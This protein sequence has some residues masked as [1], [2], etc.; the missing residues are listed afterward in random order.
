MDVRVEGQAVTVEE[1]SD[2]ASVLK[3]ALSGKRFK[4]V[5]AASV[6]GT[7]HDLSSVVPAGTGEIT[8][9]YADSPEGLEMIR[10]STAHVMALAVQR[11]FPGVLVTIGPAIENGFYYDFDVETPFTQADLEKIEAEMHKIAR[12]RIPFTRSELARAEAVTRFG[13]MGEKYK[14]EIIRDIEADHV[15]LYQLDTFCDLCRGPHVPHTG[16]CDH[17]R[18]LSCAGAYWRGDE[19]NRMLSRIYGTAFADEKSLKEHL[20]RLEEAKRRDHRKLGRELGFFTF[21]EHVAPGMVFWLPNGMLMRTILEDFWK[22]E[23]LKRGYQIVQGPQLLRQETW[24][25]S[26][27]YEHYRQN[28]YFT[29]IDEEK[30]GIK[31]MNCIGH[32]LMYGNA[33]HSYRDMPVRLFELGCVHRHEKSGVL[34]GL[35]RVRQFTQDDAHILCMP[36]QLEGEI[37]GVIRLIQ[38]LMNIFGFEYKIEI[39]TRPEDS[40]GTDEA[41]ELATNAL[42]QAVEKEGLPYSINAGDGAFYGPKIDVKLLDCIGREWQCSTIQ[43]D[44]TLPERFNLSYVGQDGEKHRPVMVHRA[45]MGSVERFIGVLIEQ[46]AGALPTWLAPEQARLLTVTDAANE[47]AETMRAQLAGAGIRV[48]L[49]DRNEKLGF[50]VRE[51]QVAKI[52]YMLVVGAREAEEGGVNIRLRNG[53]NLGMKTVEETI[54]LIKAEAAEPFTKGGMSYSFA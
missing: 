49:D 43:V 4:S 53:E 36:E 1:G 33:V 12:D 41:W 44:F 6:N 11:L 52:P 37:I 27:H 8:P 21:F 26:G 13:D 40:I 16:F 34:H 20:D 31:P 54:A 22:R 42:I 2:F 45:I 47:A 35:L 5:V 10:H 28:M 9:V 25:Q 7:S 17:V 46:F 15:S 48:T 51:A 30:Y 38:A 29:E 50:K 32:M 3:S 18:L 24:Q 39:S 19:K 23:H 14:V